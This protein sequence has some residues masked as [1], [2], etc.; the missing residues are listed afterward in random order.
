[1]KA[2]QQMA[3]VKM[4]ILVYKLRKRMIKRM[5]EADKDCGK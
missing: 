4:C 5:W 1:M 3:N 2:K